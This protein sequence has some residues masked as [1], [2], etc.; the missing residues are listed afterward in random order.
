MGL[1]R[2]SKWGYVSHIVCLQL[3]HQASDGDEFLLKLMPVSDCF[4]RILYG[5]STSDD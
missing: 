5:K 3:F 2:F 4:I 1:E